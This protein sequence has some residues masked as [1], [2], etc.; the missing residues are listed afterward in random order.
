M[1]LN[2]IEIKKIYPILRLEPI[3]KPKFNDHIE[4]E[5]KDNGVYIVPCVDNCGNDF[6]VSYKTLKRYL[7]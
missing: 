7:Q 1:K 6:Y 3:S 5:F 2:K 4:L